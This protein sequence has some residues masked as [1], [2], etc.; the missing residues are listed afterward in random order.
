[1]DCS[2][3]SNACFGYASSDSGPVTFRDEFDCNGLDAIFAADCATSILLPA[4]S[5]ADDRVT[6][7][8]RRWNL[9]AITDRVPG[10]RTPQDI[11]LP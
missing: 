10:V 7:G 1:M 3:Q 11:I 6:A 2:L 4:L 5:R 9:L 8:V